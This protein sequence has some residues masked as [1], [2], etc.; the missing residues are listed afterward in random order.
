MKTINF[1][2][3]KYE[4]IDVE[5]VS[6]IAFG[7]CFFKKG[8]ENKS[9]LSLIAEFK[10]PTGYN[11]ADGKPLYNIQSNPVNI[12]IFEDIMDIPNSP[13]IVVNKFLSIPKDCTIINL[14]A[15]N[16]L[17]KEFDV[18]IEVQID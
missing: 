10:S 12:G 1:T 6:K 3:T 18:D 8:V 17:G 7:K 4:K 9:G 13:T 11:D 16:N 15:S 5:S 14:S 2:D